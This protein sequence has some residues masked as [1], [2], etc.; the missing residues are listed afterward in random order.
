MKTLNDTKQYTFNK[1]LETFL[2]GFI[3]FY[4]W[5]YLKGY[6]KYKNGKSSLLQYSSRTGGLP[7]RSLPKLFIRARKDGVG[8]GIIK[9]DDV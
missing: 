3:I 7:E 8:S 5:D 9:S 1:F 4:Y 6:I 2:I